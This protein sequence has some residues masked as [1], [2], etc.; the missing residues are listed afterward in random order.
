[1]MQSKH[2]VTM[3]HADLGV[4]GVNFLILWLNVLATGKIEYDLTMGKI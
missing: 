3:V 1:M 2:T 4:L